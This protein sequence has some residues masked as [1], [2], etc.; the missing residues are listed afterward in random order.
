MRVFIA[1]IMQGSR[2][3]H[4]I[5]SQNYR[6]QLAEALA[7][8]FNPLEIIDP[9]SLHPNSVDYDDVLVRDTFLSMTELAGSADLVLAYLPEASMGTAIEL[10]TAHHAGV[11][12][13]VVTPMTHNWVVKVTASQV[14]SDLESLLDFI[15]SGQLRQLVDAH[16]PTD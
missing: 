15:E 5:G 9:F 6:S 16:Q 1:G 3:D 13:I 12:A 7:A 14:V 2:Q 10:W 8:Q 11:P 4:L